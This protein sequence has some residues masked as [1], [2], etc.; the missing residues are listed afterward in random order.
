VR[1]ESAPAKLRKKIRIAN[2]K[3][4][5][6]SKLFGFHTQKPMPTKT[7]VLW[8][9]E[10]APYPSS[11]QCLPKVVAAFLA[12]LHLGYTLATTWLQLGYNLGGVCKIRG[13]GIKNLRNRK[14]NGVFLLTSNS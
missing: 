13:K 2:K 8:K 10:K 11:T 9:E 6:F 3:E 4:E 14:R 7:G 1:P 5:K 12:W